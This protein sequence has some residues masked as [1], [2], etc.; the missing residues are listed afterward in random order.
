MVDARRVV[1]LG[2]GGYLGS[3][4]V[5]YLLKV[6][7]LSVGVA[8]R[9]GVLRVDA[10]DPAT[11]ANL[12]GAD[13]VVDLIDAT[14]TRPDE[15]AK[16]CVDR[17]MTFVETTSDVLAIERLASA[18][19]PRNGALILGAGI[20]TGL[21]NLL[22]RAAV[23]AVDAAES[24][25]LGIRTSP[26]SGAGKG[27][28]ALMARMLSID[29]LSLRGG[30]RV[31]HPPVGKGPVLPFPSEAAP[32]LRVPLAEQQMLPRSL[33]VRDVDVYFAPKPSLLVPAFR[34]I[35]QFVAKSSL[36]AGFIRLYFGFLRRVVFAGRATSTEMVAIAAG[37]GGRAQL[38]L[39]APDGMRAGGAAIAA[40]VA[41]LARGNT[42]RGTA[43]IDQVVALEGVL[44]TMH[45]LAGPDIVRRC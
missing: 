23:E 43:M 41:E 24:I 7:G 14:T 36:F 37:G 34:A 31:E 35:P 45:A 30:E 40:I 20:F 3:L 1:V 2:G 4:A 16:Y 10:S 5:E 19:P 6:D 25:E 17:G 13:I 27:T 11:F 22:A 9:R 42:P 38:G 15:V 33:A 26:F 28:V 18:P 12:D 32:S 39:V 44:A 21:S 8:S 29:A